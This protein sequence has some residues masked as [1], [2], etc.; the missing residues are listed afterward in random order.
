MEDRDSALATRPAVG[1]FRKAAAPVATGLMLIVGVLVLM[2]LPLLWPVLLAL[3]AAGLAA[4]AALWPAVRVLALPR[5][6]F[7]YLAAVCAGLI[8]V[9]TI[10]GYLLV[11]IF[12]AL[13]MELTWEFT[14][15]DNA[16][17]FSALLIAAGTGVFAYR[18][19]MAL[20]WSHA[21]VLLA[22]HWCIL[23]AAGGLVAA[24]GLVFFYA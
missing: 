24:I 22:V 16:F 6:N 18:K 13:G 8:A 9:Y 2:L 1:R 20:P 17:R 7:Y 3:G 4:A 23:L 15:A 19:A 21:L 5:H 10:E 12:H 11:W 14:L